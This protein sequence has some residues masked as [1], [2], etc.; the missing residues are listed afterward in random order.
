FP[1][2][3]ASEAYAEIKSVA[4][5]VYEESLTGVSPQDRRILIK[6]LEA[7]AKNLADGD[8][9][10]AEKVESAEGAAA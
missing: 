2:A 6:G 9:A 7:M 3:K 4:G 8:T 10:S 1:T 5:E